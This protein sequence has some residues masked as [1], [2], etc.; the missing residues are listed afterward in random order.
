MTWNIQSDSFI[1]A[2]IS[3]ATLKVVYDIGFSNL[4]VK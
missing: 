4:Q 2:E 1:S 3:Q